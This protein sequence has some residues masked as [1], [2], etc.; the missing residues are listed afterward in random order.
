[1]PIVLRIE[2]LVDHCVHGVCALRHKLHEASARLTSSPLFRPEQCY[3]H[4]LP[5]DLRAAEP[6]RLQG[7]ETAETLRIGRTTQLE[8]RKDRRM[9]HTCTA[10]VLALIVACGG[11]SNVANNPVPTTA[12]TS[13]PA[14]STP[15]ATRT[16]T[17]L[18]PTQ[19]PTPISTAVTLN[20]TIFI[21]GTKVD[22]QTVESDAGT[23]TLAA[24]V[25]NENNT[26]N[27]I[28]DQLGRTPVSL[29][30][31]S[32]QNIELTNPQSTRVPVGGSAPITWSGRQPRPPVGLDGAR[33]IF[34]STDNNQSSV[35]I[36]SG[37]VKTFVPK[38]GFLNGAKFES[39][40]VRIEVLESSIRAT[41]RG[42]LKGQYL[43][44]LKVKGTGKI[45][46]TGGYGF[47]VDQFTVQT[48]SGNRAGGQAP[49][50]GSPLIEGLNLDITK[51]NWIVFYTEESAG[52][53]KL[54]FKAS[55][56]SPAELSFM[57][58]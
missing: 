24:R 40:R 6:S 51:Q 55:N 34:G 44:H 18:A 9:L 32:G 22:I 46:T 1:A 2:T 39:D 27:A 14:S 8:A 10:A 38:T 56:D 49:S 21:S 42:G 29:Q 53:F 4:S 52:Q 54:L 30:T 50:D 43:L 35:A 3:W 45:R 31:S 36:S 23:I 58:P 19:V 25:A 28:E 47:G 13:R 33:I 57:I 11:G 16:P 48:P 17:P 41:Y 5:I 37:D 7:K 20:K 12:N 26:D 15:D